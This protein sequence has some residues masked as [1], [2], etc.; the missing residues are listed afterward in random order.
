M[1]SPHETLSSP[2]QSNPVMAQPPQIRVIAPSPK[3][4]QHQQPMFQIVQ[5]T[6]QTSEEDSKQIINPAEA[7]K[8]IIVPTA[9]AIYTSAPA[10]TSEYKQESQSYKSVVEKVGDKSMKLTFELPKPEQQDE[11]SSMTSEILLPPAVSKVGFPRTPLGSPS[12]VNL[13]KLPAPAKNLTSD[14]LKDRISYLISTNQAIVN[15]PMAEP[16]RPKRMM[17]QRSE[18]IEG[19]KSDAVSGS[20]SRNA[21]TSIETENGNTLSVK[22]K[23]SRA[24]SVDV[25]QLR[26]MARERE[27]GLEDNGEELV[28]IIPLSEVQKIS[29]V[30][31]NVKPGPLSSPGYQISIANQ[32]G[33]DISLNLES[34]SHSPQTLENTDTSRK[35]VTMLE[36]ET[37]LP[38]RDIIRI[39]DE[40]S[41]SSPQPFE[42]AEHSILTGHDMVESGAETK[43][44]HNQEIDYVSKG[45]PVHI[46]LESHDALDQGEFTE[47]G[48]SFACL[49]CQ[50]MFNSLKEVMSHLVEVCPAVHNAQVIP[51]N[52]KIHVFSEDHQSVLS[53]VVKKIQ[54]KADQDEKEGSGKLQRTKAESSEEVVPAQD[55]PV[56]INERKA[57]EISVELE[58]DDMVTDQPGNSEDFV[59]W[60]LDDRNSTGSLVDDATS[61]SV[62][63]S[64][65]LSSA[66]TS[67]AGP[68][69]NVV[70]ELVDPTAPLKRGRP[71][72]SKNRPKTSQSYESALSIE[73]GVETAYVGSWK[74]PP[75]GAPSFS[76]PLNVP[77]K[78]GSFD[79]PVSQVQDVEVVQYPVT[80]G[81]FRGYRSAMPRRSNSQGKNVLSLNITPH[82]GG[83][84]VDTTKQAEEED[85]EQEK[86][87]V[88]VL[89][90]PG[91][92]IAG[93]SSGNSSSLLSVPEIVVD[94]QQ[95]QMQQSS[96]FAPKDDTKRRLQSHILMKRSL[97][98]EKQ[99]SEAQK[100][101]QIGNSTVVA[102]V[103][104]VPKTNE[105]VSQNLQRS[106]S[107]KPLRNQKVK[108]IMRLTKSLE[109]VQQPKRPRLKRQASVFDV[110]EGTMSTST[111]QGSGDLDFIL[112]K[113]N[114]TSSHQKSKTGLPHTVT[115][116]KLNKDV[117]VLRCKHWNLKQAKLSGNLDI[118][119]SDSAES[120]KLDKE[121]TSEVPVSKAAGSVEDANILLNIIGLKR[122]DKILPNLTTLPMNELMLVDHLS[123]LTESPCC[124]IP[125][126]CSQNLQVLDLPKQL[127][128]KIPGFLMLNGQNEMDEPVSKKSRL[129][130]AFAEDERNSACRETSV[131]ATI[132]K[133]IGKQ[134][135]V[136]QKLGDS[137]KE[138][139]MM[140][141]SGNSEMNK[142][143]ADVVD[144]SSGN[145]E[146]ME[147]KEASQVKDGEVS[148]KKGN[149]DSE[150]EDIKVSKNIEKYSNDNKESMELDR[151]DKVKKQKVFET[152]GK[153]KSFEEDDTNEEDVLTIET[154]KLAIPVSFGYAYYCK[155]SAF[156]LRQGDEELYSSIAYPPTGHK[157]TKDRHVPAENKYSPY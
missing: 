21:K 128:K 119:Q 100:I 33:N 150:K 151:E 37:A 148:D 96:A 3:V 59:L 54:D 66:S 115:N 146:K 1:S 94:Q 86:A 140:E 109:E 51:S 73:T 25:A 137:A 149:N 88:T 82:G 153:Q 49:E 16:P 89:T 24:S 90:V 18:I 134:I 103:K 10:K 106:Q 20:Q 131:D 111:A 139:N 2:P 40:D 57:R 101:Q 46:F 142:D 122:L 70:L 35:E 72:G 135:I 52:H 4:T 48:K 53:V 22:E 42:S 85:A 74:T 61:N 110:S 11:P 7:N 5:V 116:L 124:K 123:N 143:S 30:S 107:M 79:E 97:S 130:E 81:M 19:S 147:N 99:V 154:G 102:P 58:N 34:M 26:K 64:S 38:Q 114:L 77:K 41:A 17:R 136:E 129:S 32:D 75:V 39:S 44:S 95:I 13:P 145:K 113:L 104:L 69:R 67:K 84:M 27:P 133:E 127:A 15:T 155:K 157:A 6:S 68:Y 45:E 132:N 36:E 144:V 9:S 118:Q 105:N 29:L 112:Q 43:E 76:F 8:S 126:N 152:D 156:F 63:V 117:K 121:N 50:L 55:D 23:I 87:G 120:S 138:D 62:Q 14:E 92:G 78:T 65:S 98:A 108:D 91:S 56:A 31:D 60:K 93:Q 83:L 80:E 28:S 71:R 47:E 12:V 125:K 141:V